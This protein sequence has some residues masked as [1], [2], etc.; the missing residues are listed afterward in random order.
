MLFRSS[1][2]RPS[3]EEQPANTRAAPMPCFRVA[4]PLRKVLQTMLPQGS[5]DDDDDT[6]DEND[7]DEQQTTTQRYYR[8]SHHDDTTA[9][10][11]HRQDHKSPRN[12][13]ES[14]TRTTDFAHRGEQLVWDGLS[15]TDSAN[16]GDE[17]T[18]TKCSQSSS[19]A[20]DCQHDSDSGGEDAAARDKCAT[21][22]M[23]SASDF[24]WRLPAGH[25]LTTPQGKPTQRQHDEDR[26]KNI[27]GQLRCLM[28]R[29]VGHRR[30][31]D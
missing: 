22:V 10:P 27:C 16:N 21:N 25:R 14:T 1:A 3:V 6:D 30:R 5:S 28:F 8:A 17:H 24:V 9:S 29:F 15:E 26:H 4:G 19:S 2:S 18:T 12:A 23:P 31:H 13:P 11:N 7:K 20:S